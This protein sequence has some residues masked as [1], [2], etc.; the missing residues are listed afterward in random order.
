[1]RMLAGRGH[2]TIVVSR[3]SF[4][5]DGLPRKDSGQ[6][7]SHTMKLDQGVKVYAIPREMNFEKSLY[8]VIS[9]FTPDC[10]LIGEDPTY[11]S[12][13]VANEMNVKRIVV[14]AL[15]QA[16]LPFGPEAFYPDPILTNLFKPPVEIVTMSNYVSEYI[17][18]WGQLNTVRLPKFLQKHR[19]ADHLGH[20]DNSFIMFINASKIKGLPIFVQLAQHFP[21]EKFAAVRGWATTSSDVSELKQRKNVTVLEPREDVDEIFSQTRLLLVPSLWG[22]A[23]GMVA[24][25]AM[26]RGIPV[27]ASNIGGLPEAKLNVDYLLPVNPISGYGKNLDDRLLPDPIIPKQN[28]K[29]WCEKLRGLLQDRE[30]YEQLSIESRSAAFK[31]LE[32]LDESLW[33]D[34]LVTN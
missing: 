9:Q 20:Y 4:A 27:L 1:M 10:V 12:L 25:E 23:F 21:S 15:S 18:R 24:F 14:L 19:H 33:V 8:Y 6:N 30:H 28:M 11:L 34:F 2:E 16:T 17:Q 13:A 7:A 22:E 3:N 5:K 32:G 31:Y 29:P 26:I